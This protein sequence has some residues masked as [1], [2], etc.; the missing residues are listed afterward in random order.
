MVGDI[1]KEV[2]GSIMWVSISEWWCSKLIGRNRFGLVFGVWKLWRWKMLK[3]LTS[4]ET[5]M[6]LMWRYKNLYALLLGG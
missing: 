1:V 3:N 5:W 2:V 4:L 6:I